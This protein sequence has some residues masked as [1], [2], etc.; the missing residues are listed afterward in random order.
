M[1]PLPTGTATKIM[2]SARSCL[3]ADGYASL[4]TRKVADGAGVEVH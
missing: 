3:L 1:P 4:S 2:E